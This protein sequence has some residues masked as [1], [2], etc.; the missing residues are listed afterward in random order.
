MSA[1]PPIIGQSRR[2]IERREWR[3]GRPR[4]FCQWRTFALAAAK[5]SRVHGSASWWWSVDCGLGAEMSG[6][7][8]RWPQLQSKIR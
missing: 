8:Y 4:R 6:C 3:L 1:A 2:R 5:G 7:P